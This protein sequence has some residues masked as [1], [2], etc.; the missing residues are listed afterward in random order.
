ME[1]KKE[2]KWMEKKMQYQK[3]WDYRVGRLPGQGGMP[4]LIHINFM[5][6]GDRDRM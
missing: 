5:M 2:L 3:H 6:D 4:G 1:Y